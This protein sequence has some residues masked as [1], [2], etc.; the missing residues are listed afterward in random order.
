M[1]I[2]YNL[3]NKTEMQYY[4]IYH[5]MK[6]ILAYYVKTKDITRKENYRSERQLFPAL[7]LSV[8]SGGDQ[9]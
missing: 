6:L 4:P 3:S 9:T 1:S 8:L 5:F 2:S 7:C